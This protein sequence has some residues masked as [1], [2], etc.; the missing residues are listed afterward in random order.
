MGQTVL[1]FATAFLLA[2]ISAG[3][4]TWI[5]RE[6]S[7]ARGWVAAPSSFR[8]V[9]LTPIPRLGGVAIY[10][11]FAIV[12]G[13]CLVGRQIS[14]TDL[15][16]LDTG[17]FIALV[18]P[19]TLLFLVGLIDDILDIR[20]GV[21]LFFQASAGFAF[22]IAG[23]HATDVRWQIGG[24]DYGPIV[25]ALAT[26][27]WVIAISNAVNIIDGLDGLAAGSTLFS[28]ITIFVMGVVAEKPV[29]VLL[30]TILG[31]SLI[32]FL[33]F[34]FH[35]AS[36]FL[37]DS[38]SLFIGVMLSGLSLAARTDRYPAALSMIIPVVAFGFPLVETGVSILRRFISGQRIFQADRAHIHHRLLELGLTQRQVV[39]VLYGFSAVCAL[40]S[41]VLMYPAPLSAAFVLTLLAMLIVTCLRHLRYPEFREFR[42]IFWRLLEQRHVVASSV[43]LRSAGTRLE[44]ESDFESIYQTLVATARSA[45]VSSFELVISG[46]VSHGRQV[47]TAV[48]RSLNWSRPAPELCTSGWS[49]SV[50]LVGRNCDDLGLLRV[51]GHT[52]G[53]ILIDFNVIF[54]ELGP[55]L[56]SAVERAM[57]AEADRTRRAK[58]PVR[59]NVAVGQFDHRPQRTFE[60]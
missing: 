7:I 20:A 9:H 11:T 26:V 42:R 10:S 29:V 36:I 53:N 16:P 59:D 46:V 38:G 23:L 30:A 6:V 54:S 28:I 18:V 51:H 15:I 12:S 33:K 34:N 2:I 50:K 31:G 8:H 25:S 40:L 43:A 4:L 45:N 37:G 48:A 56:S 22:Y 44:T 58:L 52:T 39:A 13:I 5:V 60:Q 24:V 35:P 32:G 47:G 1:F 27:A 21:K 19:S 17:L 49:F 3:V 41:I 55:A 14:G 57:I